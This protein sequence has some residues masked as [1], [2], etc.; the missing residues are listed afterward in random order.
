M[1]IRGEERK[2]VGWKGRGKARGKWDMTLQ[3]QE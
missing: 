2:G 1:E 3:F